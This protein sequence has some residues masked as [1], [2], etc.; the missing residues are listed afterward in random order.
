MIY[1]PYYQ[2]PYGYQQQQPV[3]NVLPPQQVI[4][5]NGKA[6]IDS[7]QLAPNSSLL[8]MDISAPLV[9]LCVS[10]GVGK[11]TATAYDIKLHEESQVKETADIENRLKA[12]EDFILELEA[13]NDKSND[14]TACKK[15]SKSDRN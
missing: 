15:Q 2:Y 1:N 10:D 8:A 7:I 13:K 12:I 14:E 6:S 9:W 4:Q 11:V 5:V 3:Q